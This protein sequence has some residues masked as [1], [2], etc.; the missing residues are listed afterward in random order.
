MLGGLAPA[1]REVFAADTAGGWF[2]FRNPV[3]GGLQHGDGSH[4][5][6]GV[7]HRLSRDARQRV[8]GIQGNDPLQESQRCA[9][10]MLGLP[11]AQRLDAQDH[12]QDQGEQGSL[13]QDHWCHRYQ[14]KIRRPSHG[15]GEPRVGTH[16]EQRFAR[17]PQ[18]SQFRCHERGIAAQDAVQETHGS[19]GRR[20]DLHRL[21]QGDCAPSAG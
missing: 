16:E 4:Q 3:L 10:G 20:Q 5:Y 1:Q 12:P 17:M 19:Q 11:R 7:L 9:C 8:C 15:N 21:P 6:D 18:L 14:G 13:G 2:L